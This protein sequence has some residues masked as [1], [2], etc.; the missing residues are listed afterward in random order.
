MLSAATVQLLAGVGRPIEIRLEAST[1][2]IAQLEP[3][4]P[5]LRD[6]VEAY[7]RDGVTVV[8]EDADKADPA[9][10]AD[11]D[12]LGSLQSHH[13]RAKNAVDWAL[14]DEDLVVIAQ[15]ARQ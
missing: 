2:T 12:F 8:V 7:R 5:V 1:T 13:G 10:L 4:V 14:G 6:F 3:V 15:S 11:D 9:A